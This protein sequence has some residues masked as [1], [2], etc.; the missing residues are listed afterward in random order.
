[1]FSKLLHESDFLVA[2]DHLNT[3][4]EMVDSLPKYLDTHEYC[5]LP[6]PAR[7]E[8]LDLLTNEVTN[9]VTK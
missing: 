3:V 4:L 6:Q 8:I 5:E 1:M 2:M 7:M 9:R